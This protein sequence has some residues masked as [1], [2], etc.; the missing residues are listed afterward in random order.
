MFNAARPGMQPAATALE[1]IR[2]MAHAID[3][4]DALDAF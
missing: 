4:L 3:D 2:R 1:F